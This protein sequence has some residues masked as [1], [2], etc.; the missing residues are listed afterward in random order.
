MIVQ[1]RIIESRV[2]LYAEYSC[3]NIDI[4]RKHAERLRAEIGGGWV[5][6]AIAG[7]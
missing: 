7:V 3:D 1:M 4:I 2:T 5:E 6:C